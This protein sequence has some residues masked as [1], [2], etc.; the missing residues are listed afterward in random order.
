LDEDFGGFMIMRLS[1]DVE[2]DVETDVLA[3]A[4]RRL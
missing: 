3:S 1:E 4:A 2:T